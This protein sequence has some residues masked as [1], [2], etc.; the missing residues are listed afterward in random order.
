MGKHFFYET[1]EA[2]AILVLV[3]IACKLFGGIVGAAIAAYGSWKA[4]KDK[5]GVAYICFI[6]LLFLVTSNPNV[7]PKSEVMGH[8]L[9]FGPI[10]I[11]LGLLV[12]TK[13]FYFYSLPLD[14]IVPF[15]IVATVGSIWGYAPLISFMKILNFLIFLIGLWVSCIN[16]EKRPDELKMVRKGLF[17]IAMIII[18]GSLILFFFP[19]WGYINTVNQ[20][21]RENPNLTS[22]EITQIIATY[23][24]I[25]LFSGITG[26]SQCLAIVLPTTIAWVTLDMLLIEKHLD[27][28]H[29]ILIL[30]GMPLIYLTRSRCALLTTGI[31]IVMVFFYA[32]SK[33]QNTPKAKHT[34]NYCMVIL[35]ILGV[36]GSVVVE[37]RDNSFSRWIRK[38][39][40]V[41]DDKR[42]FQEAILS[43]RMALMERSWDEFKQSPL[44]GTGFQVSEWMK[45]LDGIRFSATIEKGFLPTMILGET[46]FLGALAFLSFLFSFYIVCLKK[47]FIATISLFTIMLA[48]NVGEASFFSPGGT[49]GFLWNLTVGG[50]F[51]LDTIA[52]YGCKH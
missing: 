14:R 23:S 28:V 6:L 46:G 31:G 24:S 16:I 49:G 47:R 40:D 1:L 35:L 36:I 38:T 7:V 21:L 48:S 33:A 17:A 19:S 52:L 32:L 26:Q 37:A 44:I 10:L 9:R 15:I 51:L 30:V 2:T 27:K 41:T 42:S 3:L 22:E 4:I 12:T 8:C 25:T 45:N 13:R 39:N 43:S 34:M 18:L 50:G 29:L 5:P 11:T 20:L